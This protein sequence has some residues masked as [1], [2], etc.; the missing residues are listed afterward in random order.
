M[1]FVHASSRIITLVVFCLWFL[2]LCVVSC[3]NTVVEFCCST[4]L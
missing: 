1:L 2:L 3:T 4:R